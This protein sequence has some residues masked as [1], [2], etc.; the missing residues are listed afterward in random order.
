MNLIWVSTTTYGVL[1]GVLIGLLIVVI[2]LTV[3]L[4]IIVLP[5]S[6]SLSQIQIY[7][8]R[9]ITISDLLLDNNPV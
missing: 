4:W 1:I 5:I 9:A 7:N 8:T 6:N 3:L 2:M